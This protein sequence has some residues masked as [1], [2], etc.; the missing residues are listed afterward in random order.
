VRLVLVGCS[1]LSFFNGEL[2]FF[3]NL[4]WALAFHSLTYS[5]THSALSFAQIFALSFALS[6]AL[7]LQSWRS[8]QVLPSSSGSAHIK[9]SPEEGQKKTQDIFF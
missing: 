6:L 3:W 4:H 9:P 7:F 1:F 5:L 8:M 2:S